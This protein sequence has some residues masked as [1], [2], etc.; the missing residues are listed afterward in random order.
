M[1]CRGAQP[2]ALACL[3][4]ALVG[5]CFDEPPSASVR[6]PATSN[7]GAGG[8]GGE[9]GTA[10]SSALPVCTAER[11]ANC[12]RAVALAAEGRHTCVTMS[13]GTV[14]CF[15][16]NGSFQLGDP[17]TPQGSFQGTRLVQG[18]RHPE[19]VFAGREHNCAAVEGGALWCWGRNNRGQLGTGDT[20]FATAPRAIDALATTGR[21]NDA[22]CVVDPEGT[23]RCWGVLLD[24]QRWDPYFGEF[25]AEPT[26]VP[27]PGKVQTLAVASRHACAV[28]EGGERVMCWGRDSSSAL[29]RGIDGNSATPVD[30]AD[31]LLTPV[32]LI[33]GSAERTCIS[34]GTPARVQCWGRQRPSGTWAEP[35]LLPVQPDGEVVDLRVGWGHSCV[36][37]A[38]GRVQ[39]WGLNDRESLGVP[40]DH[41]ADPV[42]VTG[43]DDAVAL[44]TGTSHSCVIRGDGSVACWGSNEFGELNLPS[45]VPASWQ[46]VAIDLEVTP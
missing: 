20:D 25:N 5:A 3:S 2:G 28:L 36:L 32:H 38:D 41:S 33:S 12:A 7:G 10:V 23:V 13:D 29:G 16:A 44:A 22:T 8:T 46:P 31:S 39:C 35:T 1:R 37:L 9:G 6:V 14:R 19:T 24:G 40:G 42:G 21:A 4:L 18:L 43:L 17:H 26:V 11:T 34:A 30:V 45:N 15:G 27:L